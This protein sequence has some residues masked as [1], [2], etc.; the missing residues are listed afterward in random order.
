[1][2][3]NIKRL[4]EIISLCKE[5]LENEDENTFATMDIHDIQSLS[6]LINGY[7]EIEIRN[8]ELNKA[9][10]KEY[11]LGKAQAEY[12]VNEAWKYKINKKIEEIDNKQQNE[13][14]NKVVVWLCKQR[15]VLEELLEKE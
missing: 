5:E 7:N 10:G 1:M 12:E 11:E 14:N 2:E 13:N 6:D 15:K 9:I 8:D 3:E 4:N